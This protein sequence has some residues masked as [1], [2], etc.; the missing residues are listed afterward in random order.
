VAAKKLQT[1]WS[2]K[3]TRGHYCEL[4]FMH[5]DGFEFFS[6]IVQL[7]FALFG[8]SLNSFLSSSILFSQLRINSSYRSGVGT[9]LTLT[10]RYCKRGKSVTSL[11]RVFQV[12]M[13]MY[14]YINHH[15]NKLT[16]DHNYTCT[17]GRVFSYLL[18]F[19]NYHVSEY[20][21]RLTRVNGGRSLAC[22]KLAHAWYHHL[23][24][25]RN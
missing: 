7:F 24:F 12:T 5:R 8:M 13:F 14:F 18:Y 15:F 21:W 3:N 23:W 2:Q 16:K 11:G 4:Y 6:Q 17:L 22:K 10:S 1:T 25:S 19:T 20:K 9:N